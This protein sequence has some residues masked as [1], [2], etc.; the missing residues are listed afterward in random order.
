MALREKKNLIDKVADTIRK[1]NLI[2]TGDNLVLGVSGG[3]DSISML[4]ILLK[5]KQNKQIKEG[6]VVNKKYQ[7]LVDH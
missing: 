5:I 4:D 3:P 2:E 1:Y 7:K 6:Q